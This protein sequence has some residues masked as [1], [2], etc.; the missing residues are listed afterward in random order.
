MAALRRPTRQLSHITGGD[1][2]KLEIGYL[3]GR[4]S[5]SDVKRGIREPGCALIMSWAT[6][7]LHLRGD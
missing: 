5:L 4:T 2:V 3:F 7:D 1:G 6:V